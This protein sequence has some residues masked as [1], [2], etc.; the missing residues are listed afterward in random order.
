VTDAGSHGLRDA[1]RYSTR[2]FVKAFAASWGNFDTAA[3]I[4]AILSP[5]V[6]H[7]VPALEKWAE[8]LLWKVPIAGLL[9]LVLVRLVRSPYEIHCEEQASKKAL[10]EKL[11][12]FESLENAPQI[13]LECRTLMGIEDP[14]YKLVIM[15]TG[16]GTATNVRL[17]KIV[18]ATNSS[19]PS[20][21]I[22]TI[23]VDQS[24]TVNPELAQ[25][26]S[27]AVPGTPAP[28][29]RPVIDSL[30]SEKRNTPLNAVVAYQNQDA[31]VQFRA[32]FAITYD[33]TSHKPIIVLLGREVITPD[34]NAGA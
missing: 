1:R 20:G 6:Y 4:V 17:E 30:L 25:N 26:A 16:G 7:F 22:P 19:E 15:N 18:G 31:T 2:V 21:A 32:T 27:A 34:G 28:P 5:I 29:R 12:K 8:P 11:D 33:Y 3:T 9:A 14:G 23:F 13:F 24:E 10:K